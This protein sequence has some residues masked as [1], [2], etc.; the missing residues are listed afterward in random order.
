M[1]REFYVHAAFG[2][3]IEKFAD[4]VLGLGDGH[5]VAGDDDYFVGGGENGGG[6]FWGGAAGGGGLFGSGAGDLF[7]AEGAEEDVGEGTIH[8]FG[9][10]YGEYEAG[11]A[12]ERAGN[13]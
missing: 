3:R 9:H 4:F 10:I 8:R 6:F 12:I 5:A 2:E 13:N 7:L 1:D 11:G